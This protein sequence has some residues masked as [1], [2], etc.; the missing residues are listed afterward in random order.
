MLTC[1]VFLAAALVLAA[2]PAWAQDKLDL[3][4]LHTNDLHGHTL[5][6][7]YT[8]P[9]RSKDEQAS[10]GG[11]A[12][13]ATLIRELKKKA[14]NPVMVID[15]GDVATR[16]PLTN[17]YEGIADIEALNATGY[18]IGT[19]GNN[20]FKL[21]DAA[22]RFDATGAQNALLQVLRRSHFP[23]VCANAGVGEA[24]KGELIPGVH[25]YLVR[26][27]NGVRVG[28]LG[29][30]APRSSGYPQVK[31]WWVGDP[32]EAAKKWVPVVRKN[33]DVLVALTHVGVDDDKKIAEVPGIDAI[34]GGDSHTFLY[35]AVEV[36]GVPI[37][38]TGEFGVNLGKFDLHFAKTPAGGWKLASYDYTLL[39][40]TSK[41]KEAKDVKAVA[42]AY[43]AP[44][45]NGPTVLLPK[46]FLGATPDERTRHTS[47]AVALA[48]AKATNAEIGLHVEGDGFFDAFRTE[49]LTRY[50]IWAVMPFKNKVATLTM[51]GAELTELKQKN[52]GL[53]LS[54]SVSDPAKLYTVALVDFTA[55]GTLK[56]D[57]S[58]LSVGGDLREAVIVGLG[59][60]TP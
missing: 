20:E 34:V 6:F 2:L 56:I 18:D 55:T 15:L 3:T 16:G 59:K 39:P 50:D 13:R 19:V 23:W 26:E 41:L 51:T 60:L 27:I 58:R 5:P 40:I 48:L 32:V 49:T 14:K 24:A 33:C 22:E 57:A 38:Q 4:I 12:R 43:A 31:G 9:G 44:L 42:D 46:R 29:L 8:E 21:K 17:A 36:N 1:R 7:A 54:T 25:P 45:K 11:A 28:F 30:T 10:V 52:K 35:K 37:V 53:I 47:E